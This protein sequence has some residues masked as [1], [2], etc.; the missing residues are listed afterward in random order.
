M[1]TSI[2]ILVE[3][4]IEAWQSIYYTMVFWG[5]T[6]Y[7]CTRE[8]IQDTSRMNCVRKNIK[9]VYFALLLKKQHF[10]YAQEQGK[11]FLQPPKTNANMTFASQHRA[12]NGSSEHC[13]RYNSVWNKIGR[14]IKSTASK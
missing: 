14:Y 9:H 6:F 11:W 3:E 7:T 13:K 12:N 8:L 4:H 1:T 10:K 2:F 5:T